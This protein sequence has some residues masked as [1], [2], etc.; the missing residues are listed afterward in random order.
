MPVSVKKNFLYQASY[1]ILLIITPLVTTP[2]LS[3]TLGAEGVGMF[4]YTH[5]ITN[6]FVM[7]AT[8]GMANYGV[9]AIA[10]CGGSREKRSRVFCSAYLCQLG[11]GVVVLLA[12][13]SYATTAPQGGTFLAVIWG[14]WVI[15]ALMDVSWLLFGVEEF[16]VPTIRS[17]VTKLLSLVVIFSFVKSQN[18]L[19]IYVL[20]ISGSFFLNQVLIWPFVRRY[21]DFVKPACCEIIAHLLP[22]LR[23][24]VPVVAISLYTSLDKILLGAIAGAEQTGYFEYSEK[25]SK[26]PMALITAITTVMLPRMSS[27]VAAGN[28]QEALS[29]L[30][31]SLWAMLVLAF[32]F[33]FGIIAVAPEFA[34]V[35]LGDDFAAC[36]DMMAFLAVIIPFVSVSNVLG[37]QYLLPTLRDTKYTVSLCIGAA[38]NVA[39]NLSLIPSLG[40]MGAVIATVAAELSVMTIQ[41]FIVRNELPLMRYVFNSL[42]FL[43]MGMIMAVAVRF[44]AELFNSIWGHSV[45]GLVLE[46]LVGVVVYAVLSVAYCFVTKEKHFKA[47]VGSRR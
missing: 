7:F 9:R 39:V 30:E 46:V 33:C 42:P 24:F 6:Y 21:I 35:F 2:Y 38:V 43:V 28:K 17:T 26:I 12:Y 41:M 32:A 15:S 45:Q 10:L 44:S 20:A 22:N 31:N 25:L 4:S 3:R 40:A 29:Q 1:Q 27:S 14:L 18:D 11:V 8:L 19:W 13:V 23:L 16:K 37:K 34:P 5:A 36:D 47:I